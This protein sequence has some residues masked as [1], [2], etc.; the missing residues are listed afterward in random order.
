M[1]RVIYV[2]AYKLP[3]DNERICSLAAI[4]K[5]NYVIELL[6]ENGYSVDIISIASPNIKGIHYRKAKQFK[7][8]RNR[9]FQSPMLC[10]DNFFLLKVNLIISWLWIIYKLIR[11]KDSDKLIIYHILD[12]VVPLN[13]VKRI[14]HINFIME[15]EELYSR[16]PYSNY[17]VSKE[18][19]YLKDANK[20]IYV[21]SILQQHIGVKGI[22][23]YGN[24]ITSA[25]K[26]NCASENG[27][28]ISLLFSGTI[29]KN[30]GAFLAVETMLFL[31]SN[32][33]LY[34]T[35]TGIESDIISLKS[36]IAEVNR[37]KGYVACYYLGQ[38]SHEE[39]TKI[40]VK[41]HIALNT[42]IDGTYSE[43]LFPSKIINYL[44]MGLQVVTTPGQSI[45]HSCFKNMLHV[46]NSFDVQ[47]IANS[48]V[49]IN[50]YYNVEGLKLLQT[51][52]IT[53]LK[54]MREILEDE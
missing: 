21:S 31:T 41:S 18:M 1:K 10:S 15:V 45:V 51:L 28:N 47:D 22:V 5:M 42:Q 35:G 19:K 24:Y 14:K 53:A 49:N 17:S 7:L 8:G 38:L 52:H 44:K 32:Y 16:M 27:N 43:F 34:I 23:I 26:C 6:N 50:C 20:C 48:I 30:R 3:E 54:E 29:D 12:L 11:I 40:L 2:G 39:Y 25:E 4:N 13:I 37:K 36:K 9:L 33:T 46:V